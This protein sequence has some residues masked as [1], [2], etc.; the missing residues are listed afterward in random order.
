M[1][2]A[3]CGC[4]VCQPTVTRSHHIMLFRTLIV[5]IFGAMHT[6]KVR[7]ARIDDIQAAHG[8][9][10]LYTFRNLLNV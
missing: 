3:M 10:D 9:F 2:L 7:H 6:F 1:S 5:P 8:L 4:I